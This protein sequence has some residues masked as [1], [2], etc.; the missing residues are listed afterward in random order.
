MTEGVKQSIMET[1]VSEAMSAY[2]IFCFNTKFRGGKAVL[3]TAKELSAENLLYKCIQMIEDESLTGPLALLLL[4]LLAEDAS[5]EEVNVG[6]DLGA[7]YVH[8]DDWKGFDSRDDPQTTRLAGLIIK[9][10]VPK[11]I[12]LIDSVLAFPESPKPY[13]PRLVVGT[14][15]MGYF[16][17]PSI[18]PTSS[19]KARKI[20]LDLMIIGYHKWIDG[21]ISQARENIDLDKF[22]K[23]LLFGTREKK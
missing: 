16:S 23:G 11:L 2:S 15:L 5:L 8:I 19:D 17:G 1:I 7:L 14:A 10:G 20:V 22:N 12:H 4:H 9:I 6:R 21:R 3:S 18:E 13:D